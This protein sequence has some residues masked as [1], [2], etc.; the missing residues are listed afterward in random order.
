MSWPWHV[1]A[2]MPLICCG[3]EMWHYFDEVE[4]DCRSSLSVA[5]C[6]LPKK[7][8][9]S[10]A[11]HLLWKGVW[12]ETCLV[13][14]IVLVQYRYVA[15]PITQLR[16]QRPAALMMTMTPEAPY[17]YRYSCSTSD[18]SASVPT[19]LLTYLPPTAYCLLQYCLLLLPTYVR[20][21][22]YTSYCLPTAYCLLPTAYCLL[23][24]AY[25]LLPTAYC[26]LP[27][28]YCLLP[29]AYSLQPTAYCLLPTAYTA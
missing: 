11:N 20:P 4:R 13:C 12:R 19:V 21:T 23:P 7:R 2:L 6:P 22:A 1:A 18:N 28:A 9:K 17:S 26:L 16:A 8:S 27:T 5:Q 14:V 3:N 25:C 29:T 15:T 24:T 10:A